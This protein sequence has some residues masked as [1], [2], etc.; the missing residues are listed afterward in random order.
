MRHANSALYDRAQQVAL[1]PDH[2][3]R[4]PPNQYPENNR[5]DGKHPRILRI[6]CCH[7]LERAVDEIARMS[8]AVRVISQAHVRSKKILH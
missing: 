7:G 5:G 8:T 4:P 1:K 2:L 6:K 3:Y